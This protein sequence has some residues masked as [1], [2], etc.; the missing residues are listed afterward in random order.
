MTSPPGE[1]PSGDGTPRTLGV[2]MDPIARIH[3]EKDTTL[4]LLEAAQR[5]GWS[6]FYFEQSGLY[7]RDG[8][9]RGEGRGLGVSLGGRD[10]FRLGQPRDVALA[11]LDVVLMRK[12]PPLNLE[13]LYTCGVLE[14]AAR[15][16]TLVVNDPRALRMHNEKTFVQQFADLAPPTLV[17]RDH[18]RIL[19]FLDEHGDAVIKP[20]DGMGGASVF[21]LTAGGQNTDVIVE[22]ITLRGRRTVMVQRLIAGYEKGDKRILLIDGEPVPLALRRLPPPGQL[23]ANLAAGGRGEVSEL[24]ERDREICARLAPALSAEGLLFVGIDVIGGLLTEINVSSP[25]CMR[26]I[27]AAGG[28]DVGAQV[29]DAIARRAATVRKP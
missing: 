1:E 6:L 24:D 29:M 2:V 20:L 27:N 18:R 16:G 21:R 9:A 12:D 15:A 13:F 10:W 4:G 8:A 25:T 17:S 23:R 7:L 11:D 3:P 5:K 28:L 26:E 22:T 19:H 14:H